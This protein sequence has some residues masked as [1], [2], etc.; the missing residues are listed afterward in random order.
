MRPRIPVKSAVSSDIHHLSDRK[1]KKIYPP[2]ALLAYS[3]KSIDPA[4]NWN[5]K[6]ASIF[7]DFPAVPNLSLERSMGFPQGWE[8]L[9][10]WL[11]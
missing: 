4:D 8:S 5:V 3:L 11:P 10:L 7:V 6:A 1:T 2:A 9:N